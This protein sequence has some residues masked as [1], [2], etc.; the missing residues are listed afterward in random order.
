ML[1]SQ[2]FL[3]FVNIFCPYKKV[4][5][6]EFQP[7]TVK[8]VHH[9]SPLVWNDT[10][11][12]R[13]SKFLNHDTIS[14]YFELFFMIQ[15]SSYD[16]I[17]PLR[18][19]VIKE[20]FGIT[21][22][23]DDSVLNF[24]FSQREGA[25]CKIKM[26]RHF[27]Q[28][29]SHGQMVIG[30]ENQAVDVI[31]RRCNEFLQLGL[32]YQHLK[33]PS[34]NID[35][36]SIAVEVNDPLIDNIISEWYHIPVIIEPGFPNLPPKASFSG[37]YLMDVDQFIVTA[38]T[39]TVLSATDSETPSNLLVFNITKP[40]LPHQGTIVHLSS[41][42]SRPISSFKQSDL[43]NFDIAY[44]PPATAFRERQMYE[45]GFIISDPDFA[46]SDPFTMHIAV[47]PAITTAPRV[48]MNTGLILLEG[49][50]RPLRKSNL[51]VVDGDNIEEVKIFVTGGLHH[52][53]LEVRGKTAYSFTQDDISSESVVYH[54]DDSDSVRDS[55]HLRISDGIQST[56]F[57]FPIIIIPKDDS[58]PSL[59]INTGLKIRGKKS[60]VQ[61]L[62]TL[63]RGADHDSLDDHIRFNVT[64]PPDFGKILKKFAWV[65]DGNEISEFT[66]QDINKGL[67]YYH[68][69]QKVVTSDSF[70]IVLLDT[71]RPPNISPPYTI[72][73]Q[74]VAILND[75]P[76]KQDPA[77]SFQLEV[78]ED[79]KVGLFG[80]S[81]LHYMDDAD[82]EIIFTITTPPRFIG[83][84]AH[85]D[86]GKIVYLFDDVEDD[87][88]NLSAIVSFTQKHVNH[89]KVGYVPPAG[90][91]GPNPLF[92][93][94]I[95]SATDTHQNTV[96]GQTF[97]I[98]VLPVNN[99]APYLRT[100][101]LF[102]EE[103]SSTLVSTNELSVYD[104]DT[105]SSDLQISLFTVPLHG[106]LRRSDQLL[107]VGDLLSLDDI[108]TLRLEYIHDGSENF[109][110][111][112]KVGVNDGL[113]FISS[114]VIVTVD[115]VDDEKPVFRL[116]DITS[117]PRMSVNEG[118]SVIL[119]SEVLPASDADT[120]SELLY[121]ILTEMPLFGSITLN[122]TKVHRF[123]QKS[124]FRGEVSYLHNNQEIGPNPKEDS[125]TVIVTD[126][127]FPS[128]HDDSLKIFVTI[129]PVNSQSPRLLFKRTLLVEEGQ[130]MLV[131]E[132]NIFA[133]DEDTFLSELL[134]MIVKQPQYGYLQN[135]R[136][137]LGYES[138]KENKRI[139]AFPLQDVTNGFISFVQFNHSG[140]EPESDDF[141]ICI[142]DGAHN[143]SSVLVYVSIILVNDEVPHFY[144]SN[145]TIK[146]NNYFVLDNESV[147]ATD[148]DYP[149]DILVL[150]IK[151]E[152]KYG[153]LTYFLQA[154]NNGPMLE[155][156]F[157]HMAF[158]NFDKIVY[159]H[160]GSET[161]ED[162]FVLSLNDG[163]HSVHQTC[164]V[165]ILPVNDQ[166][167]WL[168]LNT[169]AQQVELFSYLTLSASILLA[170]D[171][172]TTPNEILYK[173]TK[174]PVHG[175]IEILN[176]SIWEPLREFTF[177][178]EDINEK[179]IRYHH[180][181]YSTYQDN[182]TFFLT[183]GQF[184]S[185]TAVFE[186][187][188]VDNSQTQFYASECFVEHGGQ[189]VLN[190]SLFS[191]FDNASIPEEIL[192]F[193]VTN[194]P[195]YGNLTLNYD[196]ATVVKNFSAVHLMNDQVSYKHNETHT[197]TRDSF[198][199]SV[200]NGV[201]ERYLTV[202]IIII[203]PSAKVN[204]LPILNHS[205]PLYSSRQNT[206]V[207]T[208]EHLLSSEPSLSSNEIIY[209]IEEFPKKGFLMYAGNISNPKNFTQ[210]HINMGL[211]SFLPNPGAEGNDHF[212]FQVLSN[213]KE[214]FMY[215][216][217]MIFEPTLFQIIISAEPFIYIKNLTHLEN[218]WKEE[219][220]FKITSNHLKVTEAVHP[221]D[222]QFLVRKQLEHAT[223]FHLKKEM[224]V[225]AFTQEDIVKGMLVITLKKNT[226]FTQD[227]FTFH[228]YINETNRTEQ[229]YG[230]HLHWSVIHFVYSEYSVCEDEGTLNIALQRIGHSNTSSVKI[231]INELT[232]R[233]SLD[234]VSKREEN[235]V[236]FD[237]GVAESFWK[238]VIVRDD[239][240][241]DPVERLKLVLS[242]PNN[243]LILTS[244]STLINIYDLNTDSCSKMPLKKRKEFN[245][246]LKE[247]CNDNCDEYSQ[248]TQME[249]LSDN[250]PDTTVVPE[251]EECPDDW[252]KFGKTCYKWYRPA[253][254]WANAQSI[255]EEQPRG[256][257]V[258]VESQDHNRWLVPVANNRPFWI[259]N[260]PE[261]ESGFTNWK[262]GS[263]GGKHRCVLVRGS[264]IW[265][266]KNCEA[267]QSFI[268][269]Q[270]I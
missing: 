118:G 252:Q 17:L 116:R 226:T 139:S 220:G 175:L 110:D 225:S 171:A 197:A 36:V 145:I 234:F 21:Q 12:F 228:V 142:S 172:D 191:A 89:R 213:N 149:G 30:H 70:E 18:P 177:S 140:M 209:S 208:S 107:R 144:L 27:N 201:I 40:L 194:P 214:G 184:N 222:I 113:H 154:I 269:E 150:S 101:E 178:Q 138:A 24:N 64:K 247:E 76:P 236:Q 233:E 9:G 182:F 11:K 72:S 112:F 35:F 54:H 20:F 181:H 128:P 25:M 111:R 88:S 146:E 19:L 71:N 74:V 183:D 241:E 32:R 57:K 195:M 249:V 266:N 218:V 196:A 100:S 260:R 52:G 43:N 106:T 133:S 83:S 26:S 90:E 242:E 166:P 63:L 87:Y 49:Q 161:K 229:E 190:S 204:P 119:T 207:I 223:L 215:D 131:T 238:I 59:V 82:K 169:G 240:K 176:T 186:V 268:C 66:Q 137:V 42:H 120:K 164:F 173:I 258:R 37:M 105:F 265:I 180:L 80:S 219:V 165:T 6:C 192:F 103:G 62:S 143:S 58:H 245:L 259:G 174:P 4:F 5:D 98:T 28:R 216:G 170:E 77:S 162:S 125:L 123:T 121:F 1:E 168:K 167:P 151:E 205:L 96:K 97:N 117:P 130:K 22:A 244:N 217:R 31:K 73:V 159:R 185:T 104:P 56:H 261:D 199:V 202:N 126:K 67:V 3:E 230:L 256:N 132:D 210:R 79:D 153:S 47:R 157:N 85:A 200:S 39:P 127:M 94:F 55:I 232:A 34:P 8:Y 160:D 193:V 264:G 92:L 91:I 255:C 23:I 61:I 109:K 198:S 13:A 254:S 224:V 60:E 148:R 152:P 16:V 50:S 53:R 136:P 237:P 203:P 257:L 122:G 78:R 65:D 51:E 188:L 38:I 115:P 48:F 187:E 231:L 189:V 81:N 246:N 211:I 95:F 239:D 141:E 243:C 75:F 147:I 227:G 262:K 84:F 248:S 10:V 124:L 253:T 179:R 46:L 267:N 93:Q 263:P 155:I 14:E 29:P 206:S 7:K 33:P 44:K 270:P 45:I 156:P 250:I 114:D 15:N 2:E 108:L 235:T 102:V 86:S 134:F 69:N 135:S 99:K 129:L 163:L 221:Q 251:A 68:L 41:D 158:E 212:Y